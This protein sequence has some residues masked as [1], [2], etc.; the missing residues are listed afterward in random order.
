VWGCAAERLDLALSPL[1]Q[2][3]RRRRLLWPG[4]PGGISVR[5]IPLENI[6]ATRSAAEQAN[7]KGGMNLLWDA[8]YT[9]SFYPTSQIFVSLA[10]IPLTP[11]EGRRLRQYRQ[12]RLR[13]PWRP[14]QS[15]TG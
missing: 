13:P 14:A 7:T 5:P 10:S 11:N 12:Y 4:L 1:R 9:R 6:I 2:E 15:S 8:P 3:W